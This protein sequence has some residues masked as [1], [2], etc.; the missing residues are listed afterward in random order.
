MENQSVAESANH[1]IGTGLRLVKSCRP[2]GRSIEARKRATDRFRERWH[3]DPAYKA[4]HREA[5]RRFRANNPDYDAQIHVRFAGLKAKCRSRGLEINLTL[6]EY[7]Q[8]VEGKV[9]YYCGHDRIVNSRGGSLDRVDSSKGYS[10]DNCVPCCYLCN[11]MKS[12]MSV[13]QF[14]GQIERILAHRGL[15]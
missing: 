9:C 7:R 10:I 13:D 4:K 6:E 8:L 1:P 5:C 11:V 2:R 3:N 14:Y 15:K 12:D